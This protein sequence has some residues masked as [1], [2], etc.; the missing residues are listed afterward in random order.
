M[1]T[2]DSKALQQSRTDSSPVR[3]GN[4]GELPGL[5]KRGGSGAA[6]RTWPCVATE[7]SKEMRTPAEL[8]LMV[9]GWLV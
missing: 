9:T 7:V 4:P 3:A 1:C 8:M 5:G 6:P 2:T